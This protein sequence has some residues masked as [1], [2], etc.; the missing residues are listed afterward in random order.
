MTATLP[1]DALF[2]YADE[3][4][5]NWEK[6]FREHSELLDTKCDIAQS[7]SLRGL[8]VHIFAVDFRYGERLLDEPETDFAVLQARTETDDLFNL[9]REGRAKIRRFLDSATDA[10]F[11]STKVFKTISV[12]EFSATRRKMAAH[13]LMHGIRHWA[14]VATF[15]RQQGFKPGHHDFLFS[16]GMR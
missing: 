16:G 7:D 5:R 8:L 11:D 3:E 12:G 10:Q 14:Q 6:F 13:T 15:V 4:A 9:G 2:T 1:L